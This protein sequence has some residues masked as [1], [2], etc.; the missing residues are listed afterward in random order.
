[1]IANTHYGY[2]KKAGKLQFTYTGQYNQREDGVVELLTSGTLVFL[3][4]AVID[5]FCVGGGGHGADPTNLSESAYGGGGG[6]GGYTA[7]AK[8]QAVSGSYQVTIGN[9][10]TTTSSAWPP[11]YGGT[12]SFGNLIS[13]NGGASGISGSGILDFGNGRNGGS[14]SGGGVRAN[15]DYGAGGY[16]GGNGEQGISGGSINPAGGNGQGTTTREFGEPNGKLYAG[17]GGGGRYMY[18]Q[19]VIS[20]GGSGG[21][22]SG[23]WS[24]GVSGTQA[25]AAGVANTGGGGGGGVHGGAS[26]KVNGA[27]GGSGICCFRVAA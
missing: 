22:G 18:G 1:M 17:G 5:I 23:G 19:A 11:T 25:A 8:S 10:A 26:F 12:T 6:A 27:S 15:S 16:D 14:G 3:N 21:G 4:P 9:G 20:M 7:T 2:V 24:G 13:A